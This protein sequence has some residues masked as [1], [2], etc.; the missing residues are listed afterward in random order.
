[1]GYRNWIY[2]VQFKEPPIQEDDRTDFFF[3]SLAAIYDQFTPGQVGCKVA[4][5]WNIGVSDGKPYNGRKCTIT[6]EEVK[7]KTQIKPV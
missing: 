1:M 4:R 2:R 7:R 6:K 5:L 3:S